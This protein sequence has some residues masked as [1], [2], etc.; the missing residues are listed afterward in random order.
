MLGTLF[1]PLSHFSFYIK[2]YQG[3]SIFSSVSPVPVIMGK[4]NKLIN[5]QDTA[6]MYSDVDVIY[7]LYHG[8]IFSSTCHERYVIM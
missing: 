6:S 2:I 8:I 3:E 5:V 4:K 7:K 1:L